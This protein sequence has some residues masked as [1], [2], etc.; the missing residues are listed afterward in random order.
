MKTH[1]LRWVPIALFFV[2][3]TLNVALHLTRAAHE[4]CRPT[5]AVSTAHL[6]RRGQERIRS[7]T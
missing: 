4:P 3:A 1:L 6:S 5:P 7:S 2:V